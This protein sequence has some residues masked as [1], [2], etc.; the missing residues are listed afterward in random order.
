MRIKI[1]NAVDKLL[2]L[3]DTAK[4]SI[5]FSHNN[6][7]LKGKS[8]KGK[9]FLADDNTVQIALTK[10]VGYSPQYANRSASL[11]LKD[12]LFQGFGVGSILWTEEDPRT[13]G[14]VLPE[15]TQYFGVGSAPRLD[16]GGWSLSDDVPVEFLRT[17]DGACKAGSRVTYS[18][19]KVR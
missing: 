3:S 6:P 9:V 17:E 4:K 18:L 8:V 14:D 12:A 13:I 10:I 15:G 11:L 1:K 2:A 19:F 16:C 5:E 7:H